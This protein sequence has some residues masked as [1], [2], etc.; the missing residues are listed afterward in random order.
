[1]VLA[2]ASHTVVVRCWVGLQPSEGPARL[3]VPD[4]ALMLAGNREPSWGRQRSN[5]VWPL[6]V[7]L[8]SRRVVAGCQ[9]YTS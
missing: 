3:E 6:H 5:Y 7:V 9:E 4:G 8:T 2:G 1:M